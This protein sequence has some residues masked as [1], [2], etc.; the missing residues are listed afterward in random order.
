MEVSAEP[1]T[2]YHL[3]VSPP[4]IA[5]S[6][7]MVLRSA[8]ALACVSLLGSPGAARAQSAGDGGVADGTAFA[9][10]GTWVLSLDQGLLWSSAT[11]A[12]ASRVTSGADTAYSLAVRGSVDRFL[13][14]WL[15][16]G[17]VA[18]GGLS[19]LELAGK[20]PDTTVSRLFGLRIGFAVPIA[21]RSVFWPR[22]SG[23][24]ASD[25][26][27]SG[28]G[29]AVHAPF[30]RQVSPGFLVGFGPA[31]E[32]RSD[33]PGGHRQGGGLLLSFAGAFPGA[34]ARPVDPQPASERFGRAG[35]WVVNLQQDLGG[36]R[37]TA[38]YWAQ[39][40]EPDRVTGSMRLL[41]TV[42]WFAFDHISLGFAVGLARV[43]QL[44]DGVEATGTALFLGGQIGGA[45]PV[46]DAWVVRPI[47]SVLWSASDA[48]T[49][50]RLQLFVP[51]A[52]ELGHFLLGLGPTLERFDHDASIPEDRYTV[53]GV[54]LTLL[55]A[56]WWR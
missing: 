6:P 55:V 25:G 56:G 15:T 3:P 11:A 23:L 2:R 54:G 5:R 39:L 32:F 24:V 26:S 18:G 30:V 45:I 21:G 7:A 53:S 19:R 1:S 42:D 22:V 8:L 52:R 48:S 43:G 50:R 28:M 16:A 9:H 40:S 44:Q 14:S 51:M 41:S 17:L 35:Q 4:K 20:P 49:S 46:G 10:G 31:Y 27:R 38:A 29:F 12:T 34:T 33:G 47:A 37:G 13:T 36:L